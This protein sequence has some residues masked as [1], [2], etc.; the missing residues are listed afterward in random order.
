M[1]KRLPYREIAEKAGVSIATVSRAINDSDRR[2]PS[3]DRIID[4]LIA[5][6]KDPSEYG[7]LPDS[8]GRIILFS[9]PLPSNPF[10]LPII[11]AARNCAADGGYVLLEIEYS[12][13]HET[14][15]GFLSL[16]AT[17]K[18]GGAII[19][20]PLDAALAER[21]DRAVPTVMCSEMAE[22]SDV[23]YAMIDNV[24]AARNAVSCLI[25][26]G[27]KRIAMI[28][29]PRTYRYARDRHSGYR[30]AL[31]EASLPWR[32]EYY[33]ELGSHMDFAMAEASITQLLMLPEPPD[34]IFCVSDMLAA[35]A[36]GIASENGFDVPGDISVMGFDDAP[37]CRMTTPRL[38]T[39]KQPV[40]KMGTLSAE[41]VM[42]RIKDR[43]RRIE[44]IMLD[45]ELAI[46]GS[47]R[48]GTDG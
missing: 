27:C 21:V 2:S 19:A 30:K 35:A 37:I 10:Y 1:T 13:T 36:V 15:D 9:T 47:V 12:I 14:L 39:V 5:L 29:G 28:N 33:S 45:T 20:N 23:P 24:G 7:L 3:S 46:R 42:A 32:P 34:A 22:G 18:A 31:E 43:S 40:G 25:A 4:A 17:T 26:S 16:L 8:R 48:R 38:S 11:E 44:S 41:M 6:G